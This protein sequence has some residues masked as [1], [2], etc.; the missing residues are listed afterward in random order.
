M[1]HKQN[2]DR[3]VRR[4]VERGEEWSGEKGRSRAERGEEQTGN[5]HR[6]VQ[7]INNTFP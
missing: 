5:T 2:L 1:T 6:Y 7:D 4:R 3:K